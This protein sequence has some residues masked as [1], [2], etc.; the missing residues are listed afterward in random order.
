[1]SNGCPSCNG[2]GKVVAFGLSR[3]P[4][5]VICPECA[6]LSITPASREDYLRMYSVR[7]L[8]A[9]LTQRRALP[10]ADLE[11]VESVDEMAQSS[12]R[13]AVETEADALLVDGVVVGDLD[14]RRLDAFD[15]PCRDDVSEV[16]G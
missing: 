1:M 14:R 6:G 2:V 4:V 15:R 9:M 7:E 11:L 12:V 13:R 8:T 10:P 16:G 3:E 5:T